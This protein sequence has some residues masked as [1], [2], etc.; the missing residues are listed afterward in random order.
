MSG[1]SDVGLFRT[2]VFVSPLAEMEAM[3]CASPFL[4]SQLFWQRSY[5][6][7]SSYDRAG[8]RDVR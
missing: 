4:P 3:S 7:F 1:M 5:R 6:G 8:S 2:E